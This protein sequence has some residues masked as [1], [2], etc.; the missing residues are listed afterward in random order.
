MNESILPHPSL[1]DRLVALARRLR[2]LGRPSEAAD[3][4]EIAAAMSP[5]GGADLRDEADGMRDEE[6][7]EDFDREFRLR[8]VEASHALG[9]ARIFE[10]R[11]VVRIARYAQQHTLC[12]LCRWHQ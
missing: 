1:I 11:G 3:L 2:S 9:M 4:L 8:N 7:V 5:D 12:C 6:S 10:Q